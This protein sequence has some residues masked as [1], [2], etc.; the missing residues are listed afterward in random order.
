MFCFKV[1]ILFYI[2]ITK[3]ECMFV[4]CMYIAYSY[5]WRPK[6]SFGCCSLGAFHLAFETWPLIGMELACC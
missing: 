4:W 2:P 1:V 5:M 6:V 3:Y